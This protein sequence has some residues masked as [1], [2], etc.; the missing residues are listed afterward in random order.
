MSK[1]S[2]TTKQFEHEPLTELLPHFVQHV[3]EVAIGLTHKDQH[4]QSTSEY[5][6]GTY[7][8]VDFSRRILDDESPEVE[9]ADKEIQAARSGEAKL[10]ELLHNSSTLLALAH[11]KL[12]A[13]DT[14]TGLIITADGEVQ[15]EAGYQKTTGS[16]TY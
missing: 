8:Q 16:V 7:V 11:A 12:G 3:G 1:T 9:F 6:G 14:I 15:Y 2:E 5:D 4:P 13:K 10:A